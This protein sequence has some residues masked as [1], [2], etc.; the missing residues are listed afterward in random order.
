MVSELSNQRRF[1]KARAIGGI[2]G[3]I[4]LA[5][6]YLDQS[7]SHFCNGCGGDPSLILPPRD[8]NEKL[9]CVSFGRNT[10][11]LL[12]RNSRRAYESASGWWYKRGDFYEELPNML[13]ELALRKAKWNPEGPRVQKL[14]DG[15]GLYLQLDQNGSKYW[16]GK[17][18]VERAEVNGD[19]ITIKRIEK[20]YSI[21]TYPDVLAAEARD[22]WDAARKLVREGI[23]PNVAKK[24]RK[25]ANVA[26]SANTFEAIAREWWANQ[27]NTWSTDHAQ[28]ILERLEQRVFP[29]LGHRPMREITTQD[30]LRVVKKIENTKARGKK[31]PP[32]DIA[33]RVLRNLNKIFGYACIT[34]RCNSNPVVE[35]LKYALTVAEKKHFAALKTKE[36]PEFLQKLKHYQGSEVAK[37]ATRIL[38]LTFVRTKEMSFARWPEIDLEKAEWF[39]PGER[40]KGKRTQKREDHYVP[41]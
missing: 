29:D 18:R 36:L 37:A 6:L 26:A 14:T 2:C 39:V 40:M 10:G 33:P 27:K 30:I 20:T 17:Y 8:R 31:T 12:A 25:L 1:L 28:T 22:Q 23:D 21:G 13:S 9:R 4:N 41:L 7:F 32:L 24:E 11:F 34:L 35:D 5:Y 38:M 3:V 15:K 16:R 19:K